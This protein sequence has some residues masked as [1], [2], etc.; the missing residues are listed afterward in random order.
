MK[1]TFAVPYSGCAYW[2]CHQPAKMI[3]KLG[4]AEVRHYEPEM[5]DVDVDGLLGWGD[6]IVQQSSMGI[7]QVAMAAKLKE[8]GK[9]VVGDYDDLSFSV[10]PFNPAYKTMGLNDVKIKHN[11]E[12]KYLWED[13]KD[14][15]SIKANYFR[16]KSLQDMLAVLDLVTTTNRY[17]KNEYSKFSNNI[18]I[19]PNSIDFNLYKP[20]PKKEN[21]Q[22]RIGWTASDSHY[23]EIW[24]FKRIMRKI[25]NKYGDKVRIVLLGNLFEVSQE[26]QKDSYERHD[27]IGLDTYPLKQASLQL[28][29]GLC[30]LDNIPFNRAKSQLKWS[31]YASL[32]IPSVCSKLEPYDCVEDGVTGM[33]A[34]TEDEFFDKICALIEDIKLRKTISDNAFEENYINYN[35]EKNAILW[36]EAYEQARD[37]CTLPLLGVGALVKDIPKILQTSDIK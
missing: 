3:K 6:V 34:T 20:F 27:F 37:N 25:F 13:G 26:F 29:I 10:S 7:E 21:K 31:E 9:T 33:L 18:A 8:L 17:I 28:D 12:E 1:I 19:L 14:G 15:F 5:G 32:R 2:R 16:Y 30:P 35:L 36:V 24:M 22:V 11:G 23:S 4:L